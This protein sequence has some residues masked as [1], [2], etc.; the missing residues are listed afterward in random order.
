MIL[1]FSKLFTELSLEIPSF[2]HAKSSHSG[3]TMRHWSWRMAWTLAAGTWPREPGW[4][5]GPGRRWQI[6]KIWR[7]CQWIFFLSD[8]STDMICDIDMILISDDS[9]V[10]I[11]YHMDFMTNDWFICVLPNQLPKPARHCREGTLLCGQGTRT[12]Q[13]PAWRCGGALTI[14]WWMEGAI[15][16]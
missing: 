16:S 3:R 12:P 1:Y 8:K 11:S 5:A 9:R 10:D 13:N 4:E 14:Q 15:R 7:L 2:T 6:K